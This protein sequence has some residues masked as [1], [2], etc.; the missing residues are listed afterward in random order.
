MFGID[1]IKA[2][3]PLLKETSQRFP[4]AVLCVVGWTLLIVCSEHALLKAL[5]PDT[6]VRLYY[7]LF[8]GFFWSLSIRLFFEQRKTPPALQTLVGF[9]PFVL[10]AAVVLA[11]S[12]D[13][14]GMV[15]LLAGL[16]LL[17]MIAPYIGDKKAKAYDIWAFNYTNGVGLFFAAAMT[18]ILA[19]G[20]GI[21]LLS[22]DYLFDVHISGRIYADIWALSFGLGAVYFL[23]AVSAGFYFESCEINK[24]IR[25]IL[26]YIKVPLV[27]VYMLILYAYF[28]KI[29]LSGELPRGQ[30]VY[31]ITF[32][33]GLGVVTHMA[34]LPMQIESTSLL[35]WFYRWFYFMLVPPLVL[36]AM[37]I[38]IRVQQ[39]GITENRYMVLMA[40]VWFLLITFAHVLYRQHEHIKLTISSL[41]VLCFLASF[42]PWSAVSVS[43]SSQFSRFME[44]V[45]THK[46]IKEDML[47]QSD[48]RN[49]AL[50]D[51]RQMSEALDYLSRNKRLERFRSL[52]ALRE[53][54]A[55]TPK[56]VMA[57]MGLTYRLSDYYND[58]KTLYYYTNTLFAKPTNI[59]GG[60]T[61]LF[62]VNLGK[63]SIEKMELVD[64]PSLTLTLRDGQ[65]NITDGEQK[66]RFDISAVARKLWD[67]G[68]QSYLTL[69]HE[70]ALEEMVLEGD[71]G[72]KPVKIFIG[73]IT[74]EN[75]IGSTAA[76]GKEALSVTHIEVS[77][78]Y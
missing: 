72:G 56:A 12:L 64:G 21:A 16:M 59:G 35:R 47:V 28:I 30:L 41:V 33:A 36:L 63:H 77:V 48:K 25:F 62:K 71:M 40:L 76:S 52:I 73:S 38:S 4:L 53:D 46:L 17:V 2:F 78:L 45:H 69:S 29:G 23:S 9:G 43:T 11:L 6:L 37:A 39:Y 24:R 65:L 54:E 10:Y 50:D 75:P 15:F 1:K 27:L 13:Y 5:K 51:E 7:L 70:K 22:I 74:A 18:L 32:F 44:Y 55:L 58:V 57:Y 20:V 3:I 19:A 8:C 60:F 14:L 49:I 34:A 68:N 42:G 66:V 31:M 61:H 26:S 67:E